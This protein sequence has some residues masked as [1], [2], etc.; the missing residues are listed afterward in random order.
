[1]VVFLLFVVGALAQESSERMGEAITLTKDEIR[2]HTRVIHPQFTP[3]VA[4][5]VDGFAV[6]TQDR[7][8]VL[9]FFHQIYLA[10]E[11]YENRIEWTGNYQTCD[12]G[13]VAADFLEDTRRRINYFRR[14]RGGG[15][16]H[17][18]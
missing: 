16:V 13:A 14:A 1:M 2:R 3:G 18:A 17:C 10:S 6:D 7:T 11:G 5:A 9:V 8:D 12:A 4:G 15:G